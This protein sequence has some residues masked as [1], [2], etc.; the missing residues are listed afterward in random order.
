M[1]GHYGEFMDPPS[2]TIDG[3]SMFKDMHSITSETLRQHFD[4][5]CEELSLTPLKRELQVQVLNIE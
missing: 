5:L 2:P 1:H 4:W 3:T